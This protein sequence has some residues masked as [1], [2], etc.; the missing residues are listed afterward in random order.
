[1]NHPLDRAVFNALTG[2]LSA[3]ATADSDARAVRIDPEVG[4]FLAAADASA[5]SRDRLTELA[6][7]HPGAGLVERT[8]RWSRSCRMFRSRAACLWCR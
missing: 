3:F 5:Q 1:M 2:R 6:R 8:A 4:V 7:R